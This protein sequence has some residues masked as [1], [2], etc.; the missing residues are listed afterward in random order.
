MIGSMCLYVCR[1]SVCSHYMLLFR[2]L[3]L[4]AHLPYVLIT[5]EPLLILS[6]LFDTFNLF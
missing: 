2:M 3:S 4:Y 5:N 1:C 6:V